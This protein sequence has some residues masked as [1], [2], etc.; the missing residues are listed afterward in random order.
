LGSNL[1]A[2]NFKQKVL[3]FFEN[4]YMVTSIKILVYYRR[5]WQELGGWATSAEGGS[6]ASGRAGRGVGR[7]E[8]EWIRES[9]RGGGKERKIKRSG[10]WK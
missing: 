4:S 1:V 6:F 9:G 3:I 8:D 10:K 5:R 7:E 2:H